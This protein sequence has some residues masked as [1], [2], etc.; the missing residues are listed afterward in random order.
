MIN[1]IFITL[2]DI[3]LSVYCYSVGWNNI[4]MDKDFNII[5]TFVGTPKK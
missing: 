2:G 3:K 4:K 1:V 5:V